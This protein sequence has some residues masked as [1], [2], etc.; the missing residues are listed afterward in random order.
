ML[1]L[2]LQ[3]LKNRCDK[4]PILEVVGRAGI[5]KTHVIP[6]PY[7]V[8]LIP[9]TEVYG[10]WNNHY[11]IA[12][13]PVNLGK[14]FSR[15]RD[16]VGLPDE[17]DKSLPQRPVPLYVESSNPIHPYIALR[18]VWVFEVD[19]HGPKILVVGREYGYIEHIIVEIEYNL[20]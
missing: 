2:L 3:F 19:L 12:E 4:Q 5:Q 7:E 11:V 10:V 16:A 17:F 20:L 18:T 6:G 8:R 1:I 9:N 15:N 13:S 14:R